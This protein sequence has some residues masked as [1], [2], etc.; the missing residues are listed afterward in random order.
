MNYVNKLLLNRLLA[1]EATWA[2]GRV[3]RDANPG[4]LEPVHFSDPAEVPTGLA[5]MWLLPAV[6]LDQ[7]AADPSEDAPILGIFP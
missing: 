2:A 5:Q 6:G 4:S 7:A 1:N 3:E